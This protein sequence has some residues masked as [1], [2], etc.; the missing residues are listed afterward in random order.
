MYL[1]HFTFTRFPFAA[2]L[3]ADGLFGSTARHEAE[4]RLKHLIE[5]RGLGLLTGEV[6]CGKTTVCRHV[7]DNLQ[8]RPSLHHRPW[9]SAWRASKVGPTGHGVQPTTR[10]HLRPRSLR[11]PLPM[12][13]HVRDGRFCQPRRPHDPA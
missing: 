5:L 12:T 11:R 2:N 7:T 13:C 1:H 3:E 9:R 6:G 8:P 10:Q 4:A